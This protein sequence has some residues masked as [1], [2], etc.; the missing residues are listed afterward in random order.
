MHIISEV[1]Q[2]VNIQEMIEW[3]QSIEKI[4]GVAQSEVGIEDFELL[5]MVG[6]GSYGRVI[7]V[8]TLLALLVQILTPEERSARSAAYMYVRMMCVCVC[9]CV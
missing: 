7:Q 9:V 6:K 3:V 5:T 1:T 8:L 4:L 2:A